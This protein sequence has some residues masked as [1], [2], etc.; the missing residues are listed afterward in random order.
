MPA[1]NHDPRP[2]RSG[3]PTLRQ[4]RRL[5]QATPSHRLDSGRGPSR[6]VPSGAPRQSPTDTGVG[7]TR[8]FRKRAAAGFEGA[9][10]LVGS[11]A[12][13]KSPPTALRRHPPRRSSDA[14]VRVR[15]RSGALER[16]ALCDQQNRASEKARST[17]QPS[18]QLSRWPRRTAAGVTVQS[19][20]RGQA[21]DS[22]SA[23]YLVCLGPLHLLELSHGAHHASAGQT[24]VRG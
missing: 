20:E 7:R 8:A 10:N 23:D 6:G 5:L 9:A 18:S 21:E 12:P 24:H 19:T 3:A 17:R 4:Q 15:R 11:E 1:A 13:E 22:G 14:S 2:K 16:S